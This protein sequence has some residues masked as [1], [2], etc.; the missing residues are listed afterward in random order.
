MRDQVLDAFGRRGMRYNVENAELNERLGGKS[1]SESS[2]ELYAW[3]KHNTDPASFKEAEDAFNQSSGDFLSESSKVGLTSVRAAMKKIDRLH[4]QGVKSAI[5]YSEQ[6]NLLGNIDEQARTASKFKDMHEAINNPEKIKEADDAIKREAEGLRVTDTENWK[7]SE[8]SNLSLMESASGGFSKLV[9]E[10]GRLEKELYRIAKQKGLKGSLNQIKM[11]LG[12]AVNDPSYQEHLRKLFGDLDF[13]TLFERYSK[14][15]DTLNA[16]SKHSG[17]V[18]DILSGRDYSRN[19]EESNIQRGKVS[20]FHDDIKNH[21]Q[22]LISG[23]DDASISGKQAAEHVLAM[24]QDADWTN[25]PELL[26]KLREINS[27]TED[28]LDPTLWEEFSD[29]YVKA[30]LNKQTEPRKVPAIAKPSIDVPRAIPEQAMEANK[31]VEPK[32]D[33]LEMHEP[34]LPV[35]TEKKAPKH[36]TNQPTD[37]PPKH[38]WFIPEKG[39]TELTQLEKDLAMR[40]KFNKETPAPVAKTADELARDKEEHDELTTTTKPNETLIK[41]EERRK[42]AEEKQDL[43][44]A[45]GDKAEQYKQ[46]K[47][48]ADLNNKF[49]MLRSRYPEMV[50]ESNVFEDVDPGTLYSEESN[51]LKDPGYEK[52]SFFPFLTSRIDRIAE[53]INLP[54]ARYATKQLHKVAGESDILEGRIG[55]AAIAAHKE[56][57][58]EQVQKIY[59]YLHDVDNFKTSRITLTPAEKDVANKITE[60]LRQPRG[61]K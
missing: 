54:E 10:Q 30:M 20:P 17:V 29:Q 45:S 47:R 25:H 15:Q 44:F 7:H 43:A 40:R 11:A 39:K 41:L 13:N 35:A 61:I 12:E 3:L 14:I 57:L 52:S 46:Q 6:S 8:G 31:P 27:N 28:R 53:K 37:E 16:M 18:D 32:K 59:R 55:N 38:Q 56:M 60:L 9:K 1:L 4:E 5:R 34:E 23:T 24:Q 33:Y 48:I 36:R 42:V 26:K 51:I 49:N 21:L 19:S 22:E 58:P 50:R 2:N